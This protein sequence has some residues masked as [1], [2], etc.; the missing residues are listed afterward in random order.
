MLGVK[1]GFNYMEKM[2]MV[3]VLK[4]VGVFDVIVDSVGGE[5]FDGLIDVVVLGGWIV[6]FGVI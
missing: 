4:M 2:W 5:G 6:F 3:E 1:G